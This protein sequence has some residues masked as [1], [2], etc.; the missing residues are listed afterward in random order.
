MCSVMGSRLIASLLNN[1]C[2]LQ[3]RA[4]CLLLLFL[5]L[6][7]CS[8][9]SSDS[10]LISAIS[11][12]DLYAVR[13]MVERGMNIN[14]AFERSR[15]PLMYAVINARAEIVVYLLEKGADMEARDI[16]GDTAIMYASSGGDSIIVDFLIEKGADVNVI[17]L[18]GKTA[19]LSAARQ[20]FKD[21]VNMLLKAG[22]NPRKA[23]GDWETMLKDAE[24][25]EDVLDIVHS[26]PGIDFENDFT[27]V[28]KKPK[29]H[30][31]KKEE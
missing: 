1:F 14:E 22:A 12:G 2:G 25:L 23:G 5:L 9:K 20:G 7:S 13:S 3:R 10:F 30:K 17:N 6:L 16:D 24:V 8:K 28:K 4:V 11:E 27:K 31:K 18:A 29:V 19:L 15:T 21:V 26:Q